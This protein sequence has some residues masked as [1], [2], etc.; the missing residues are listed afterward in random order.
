[1]LFR[2]G[3]AFN[4]G[5]RKVKVVYTDDGVAYTGIYN[6][7]DDREKYFKNYFVK[8]YKNYLNKN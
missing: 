8:K 5:G 6:S 4:K 7:L 3:G 1:V 2:S